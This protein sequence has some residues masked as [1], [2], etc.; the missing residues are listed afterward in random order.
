MRYGGL[1]DRNTRRA[2][3]ALALWLGAWTLAGCLS[4]DP[5]IPLEIRTLP[6]AL[7]A[8]VSPQQRW[9]VAVPPFQDAR[10]PG[11]RLG[12]RAPLWGDVSYFNLE[13][14]DVGQVVAQAFADWLRLRM[15]WGA[16]L[17]KPGVKPPE[18]GAA[19][20]LSGRVVACEAHVRSWLAVTHIEV[21]T[22][23]E[24]EAV[25]GAAGEP[26]PVVLEGVGSRWRFGFDPRD[27]E[28]SLNQA[29]LDGFEGLLAQTSVEGGRLRRKGGTTPTGEPSPLSGPGHP[30]TPRP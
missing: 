4:A 8:S 18:G 25:N 17:A 1:R 21:R 3:G 5:I 14:G 10:P 23:L 6:P 29:L 22:R 30:E 19:F 20:T 26:L 9:Q 11:S 7:H 12:S 2:P 28:A 16:W 24:V 13:G 27:V 15:G